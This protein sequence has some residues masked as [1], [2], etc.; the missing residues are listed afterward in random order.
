EKHELWGK[1]GAKGNVDEITFVQIREESAAVVAI[2]SGDVDVLVEAPLQQLTQLERSPSVNTFDSLEGQIFA[3]Y[4]NTAGG[5]EGDP[6][7]NPVK[8]LQNVNVRRAMILAMDVRG[9]R[10]VF[11]DRH[12]IA[13]GL[14]LPWMLGFNDN[15][16]AWKPQDIGKAKI[17]MAEAGYKDG[18][19]MVL[20]P[21]ARPDNA[22]LGTVMGPMLQ[23][24]G[25]NAEVKIVP[26]SEWSAITRDPSQTQLHMYPF[27]IGFRGE[28]LDL[29]DFFFRPEYRRNRSSM[30]LPQLYGDWFPGKPGR[31]DFGPLGVVAREA[32]PVKR[33]AI[34]QDIPSIVVDEA[35]LY[36]PL[37]VARTAA[38]SPK[39]LNWNDSRQGPY[40][41]GNGNFNPYRT[42]VA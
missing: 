33:A 31:P 30:D 10:A 3:V 26:T 25:I 15:I 41:R 19:D 23:K 17:L 28:S 32:D 4:I 21:D 39:I 38:Y 22:L 9:L 6:N 14:F 34:Y 2:Q 40:W 27:S 1:A 36:V 12:P 29:F 20:G 7:A 13:R 35:L 8:A 24:I 11:D 37:Y 42:I 16:K 18:F 5:K